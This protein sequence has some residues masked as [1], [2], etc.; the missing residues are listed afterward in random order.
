MQ[1]EKLVL[2]D[3]IIKSP[4][5]QVKEAILKILYNKDIKTI[6]AKVASQ[7]LDIF[8]GDIGFHPDKVKPYLRDSSK[9][10]IGTADFREKLVSKLEKG[11]DEIVLSEKKQIAKLVESVYNNCNSYDQQNDQ[12]ILEK[13]KRLCE[14]FDLQVEL[15]KVY[16]ALSYNLY[17]SK[18]TILKSCEYLQ[19]AVV[20]LNNHP[21]PETLITCLSEL[22]LYYIFDR[23]YDLAEE[24][25]SRAASLISEHNHGIPDEVKYFVTYRRGVLYSEN[26]NFEPARRM[27]F[28]ALGLD[29]PDIEK[30]NLFMNIG[31]T[32]K[33][34]KQFG[35]AL[36][37]YEMALVHTKDVY[38]QGVIYNNIADLYRM[39]GKLDDAESYVIKAF[40]CLKE[41][42]DLNKK[43]IYTLTLIEINYDKGN[44]EQVLDLVNQV[45]FD[46]MEVHKKYILFAID[47]ILKLAMDHDD[48]ELLHLLE[49]AIVK[50]LKKFTKDTAYSDMLK[51]RFADVYLYFNYGGEFHEKAIT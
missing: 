23:K 3:V 4:G 46:D 24:V 14:D 26:N 12:K 45:L 22:G 16:R 39:I 41:N 29:I 32:F 8:A 25:L 44:R 42:N 18:K 38:M 48:G 28:N 9:S 31:V 50:N 13:L 49:K 2:D 17:K 21:A 20:I 5:Y 10:P 36:I 6:S 51:Q 43:L 27:F 19:L 33:R 1:A 35:E 37:Y 15:A 40:D 11:Y 47:V 34:S 7:Y 30:A